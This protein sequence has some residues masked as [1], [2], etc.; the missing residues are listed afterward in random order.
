M[1]LGASVADG[2]ITVV[3]DG[4]GGAGVSVGGA[5]ASVGDA[6]GRLVGGT[7]TAEACNGTAVATSVATGVDVLV[8]SGVALGVGDTNVGTALASG[9]RVT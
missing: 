9:G 8:G 2:V 3:A 6:G 7:A 4:G 1:A 5:G